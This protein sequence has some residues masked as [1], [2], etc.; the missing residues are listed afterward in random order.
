MAEVASAKKEGKMNP[1]ISI[2]TSIE[3]MLKYDETG[4]MLIFDSS[5]ERFADF[6]KEVVDE[7]SKPNRVR[8]YMARQSWELEKK[9]AENGSDW[10]NDV[11][12][13]EQ[14]ASP[15]ERME[16]KN[17]DPNMS[18]YLATPQKMHKH[19]ALGYE[20]VPASSSASIGLSGSNTMGTL[21]NT[22]YVLMQ[23][24]KENKAK[25]NAM[26]KEKKD[27]LM[28][29]I[30]AAAEEAAADGNIALVRDKD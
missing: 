26:K 12:I 19:A 22:E 24:T 21:G 30:N 4:E 20:K 9:E 5:P 6:P 25:I 23:T 28:G 13:Q 14:Y 29:N 2:D 3:D 18:Y 17:A 10:K 1:K 11:V 8:F 16:V 7:L 27:W 15:T